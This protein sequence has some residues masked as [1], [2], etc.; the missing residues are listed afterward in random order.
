MKTAHA[1][2]CPLARPARQDGARR[3]TV[4]CESSRR[5]FGC[6]AERRTY[7]FGG[8]ASDKLLSSGR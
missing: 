5:G 2:A 8:L 1:L 6:L 7:E 3:G 4:D